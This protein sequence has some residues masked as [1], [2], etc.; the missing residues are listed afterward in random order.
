MVKDISKL[1]L[2]GAHGDNFRLAF[3][4][5]NSNGIITGIVKRFV[6][7]KGYEYTDKNGDTKYARYD[8]SF[9]TK[10]SDLFGL[11]KIEP[12][13]ET[14]LIVEGYPDALYFQ[15][16]GI[17]NITAV[18]QGLLSKKH[19]DGIRSKNIKNVI[20]S[21]DND[22]VGP[23]NTEKAVKLVLE[24]SNTVAYVIDPDEYG[25]Y[26]D[27]D[28]YFRANGLHSLLTIFKDKPVHGA[29]WV[30][31]G[32]IRGYEKMNPI[33]KKKVEGKIF[34]ILLL[35]RD[36]SII[37]ELHTELSSIFKV[38][39][40][41][42]KKLIR[43]KRD[44][45]R[46]KITE[47][48]IANP[49]VPFIDTNSN[50]RGYYR[51]DDDTLNLGVDEKIIENIM[52]DYGVKLPSVY[53]VFRVDFNPH[54]IGDKFNTYAKTFNLF[55][56]TEFMKQEKN[57]KVLDLEVS[58]PR[59]FELLRNLIPV[60]GEREHFI[61]WLSFVFST[62][63]KARTAWVFKGIQGS[64]KNL[65]FDKVIKPLFGQNQ[66]IVVDDDRLQSDF[67]GFMNNKLFIAFNEVANDETK[68]K[69]SVK[70]KIKSLITD[71]TILIN[72]KHVK[73]YEV[74]NFANIIFFSN[75]VIPLLI[76]NQDRRFNVVETG[77]ELYSVLSFKKDPELFIQNLSEELEMF[78]QF[79]LN[80]KYNQLKVDKVIENDAKATIKELSMNRYELF[81]SKLKA[82]DWDWFDENYPREGNDFL[83]KDSRAGLMTEDQLHSGMVLREVLLKTY[84]TINDGWASRTKLTRQFNLYGVKINRKR[85]KDQ[86]DEYYYKW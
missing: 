85:I 35:I 23:D 26:K 62:R 29:V 56:P 73:T 14:I 78:T 48:I 86:P 22:G 69:K 38:T 54:E 74:N 67:N 36:E 84:N 52:I 80:Y 41:A 33:E 82:K 79:L 3:P 83:G 30:V 32:L 75:E 7:S 8:S 13:E 49:I 61:N 31:K 27:P 11:D 34:E 53:P 42:F 12:K 60:A 1:P 5:Y 16:N 18:G 24:N 37:A 9:G 81:A 63:E 51:N 47:S 55:T 25:N 76:E 65:F 10:K 6:G 58:C 20:I 71:T 46:D 50:T 77:G 40:P 39:L 4:Y 15:A 57:D 45:N 19:L 59:I 28:E 21:F 2:Q 72:E 64:G 17:K 43:S 68:T 70:S 44:I 66:A